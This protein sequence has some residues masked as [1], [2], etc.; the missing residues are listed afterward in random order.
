MFSMKKKKIKALF[1]FI[2]MIAMMIVIFMFSMA[3]GEESSETSG[4]LLE[5]ILKI[6]EKITNKTFDSSSIDSLHWIIRKC[7]H[8]GEYFL[9]GYFTIF[10]LTDLV[11]NKWAAC[12]FSESFVFIYA[13]SDEIHQYFVPGRYCSP[14]D[15]GIDSLGALAGIWLFVIFH[16]KRKKKKTRQVNDG[17][18]EII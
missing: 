3:Q 10:A 7:G 15:V 18:N 8:F 16:R 17:K 2:P 4:A 6:A 12:I 1:R 11:K 5:E 13:V 9:L 14:G